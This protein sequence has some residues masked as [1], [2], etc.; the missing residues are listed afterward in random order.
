MLRRVDDSEFR[1][2]KKICYF[3]V[4][5]LHVLFFFLSVCEDSGGMRAASADGELMTAES[6]RIPS[7]V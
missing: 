2:K 7:V 5:N 3:Q 6:N 4:L 1:K